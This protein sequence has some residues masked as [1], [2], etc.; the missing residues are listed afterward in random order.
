MAAMSTS[1]P[2]AYLVYDGP[3]FTDRPKA[4]YGSLERLKKFS[5]HDDVVVAVYDR[6]VS[7]APAGQVALAFLLFD[8]SDPSREPNAAFE[9]EARA[10][11]H[12]VEGLK[13]VPVFCDP[14]A[15]TLDL[16]TL[17]P[18]RLRSRPSPR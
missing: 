14:K 13:L 8:E 1:L 6:P 9:S 7:E 2:L 12:Q 3:D 5:L 4:A 15:P 17:A 18:S 11:Q 16:A 10:R